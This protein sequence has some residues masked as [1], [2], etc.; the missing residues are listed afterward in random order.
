[1][2]NQ[3]QTVKEL[4]AIAKERKIA[5]Y[6]KMRRDELLEA[7][8]MPEEV[9]SASSGSGG[10]THILDEP[11]P[12]I[13]VPILRP[14]KY[15]PPS[16]PSRWKTLVSKY[17]KRVQK[18][19]NKFANWILNYVPKR[20]KKPANERIR[21]LKEE[22]RSIWAVLEPFSVK[23][24]EKAL[25]GFFKTYR[26]DGKKGY[27][28]QD[29]IKKIKPKV[30]ELL[31]TRRKPIK[32]KFVLT[33]TFIKEKLATGKIEESEG[34]F[35]TELEIVTD[36]TDL[37]NLFD[38]M[39]ELQLEKVAKFE[40]VKSGWQ[41]DRV[42]YF[43]IHINPF[44]PISGT[45]YIP[46]PKVLADKKAIIN[47]KNEEDNECFKW[48]VTS[49]VFPK[50]KD[51]QRLNG[52]MRENSEKFD[53][54]GMEFPVTLRDIAKFERQNPYAINVYG[55]ESGVNVLRI[56]KRRE[57][58]VINLLLL[59]KDETNHY[60]WIKNLSRLLSSQVDKH[61][62]RKYFCHRCLNPFNTQS[63]L[64]KHL[65]CCSNHEAV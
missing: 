45:S 13:S 50:E 46:L 43:D 5:K 6:Y 56:S 59:S 26:I 62:G 25:K 35:H 23:E 19:I 63:S 21:K 40:G 52:E 49:A 15:V 29:F 48:A 28:P 55:Y 16:A 18:K 33:C 65:E 14:T 9:P 54:S 2:P 32:V 10:T 37:S 11:V 38:A 12:E 42:E 7:L 53:W 24:K 20:I 51:G 60:C 58:T 36:S 8:G 61:D 44:E 39:T 22:V 3:N 64:D 4:R 34:Y 57:V 1:M 31:Y 17:N 41:F 47:V 30:V 27:G